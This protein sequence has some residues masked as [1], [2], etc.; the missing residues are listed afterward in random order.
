MRNQA[1]AI[2]SR[3]SQTMLTSRRAVTSLLLDTSLVSISTRSLQRPNETL[4]LGNIPGPVR[5]VPPEER[6]N[7]GRFGVLVGDGVD[8]VHGG[9]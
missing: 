5:K 2:Y 4:L 6:C 7:L 1:K 8:G 3:H 9:G